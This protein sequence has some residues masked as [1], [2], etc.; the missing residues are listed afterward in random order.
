MPPRAHFLLDQARA[1]EPAAVLLPAVRS[2]RT[3]AAASAT[4]RA[5]L[6]DQGR[7]HEPPRAV[8]LPALRSNRATAAGNASAC[9]RPGAW[10]MNPRQLY[11]PAAPSDRAQIGRA[12]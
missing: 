11:C 3:T 9:V 10:R 1:H 5:A 4:T 8:L 12:H 6:L 2:S 7:A